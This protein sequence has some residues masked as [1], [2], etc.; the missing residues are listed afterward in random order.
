MPT[1][2]AQP[3]HRPY[4]TISLRPNST[5][6]LPSARPMPPQL[7]R[8]MSQ[9]DASRL[10]ARIARYER[11]WSLRCGQPFR[12]LSYHFAAPVVLSDG[13]QAV[14]KLRTPGAECSAE[15][16]ALRHFDGCGT[17][18]GQHKELPF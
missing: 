8:Y 15:V 2:P 13:S 7:P 12:N 14:L 9:E 4:A 6:R 10:A 3:N 1:L 17:A 11:L 16:N 18:S 5:P